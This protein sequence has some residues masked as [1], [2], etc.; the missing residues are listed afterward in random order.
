[1][2]AL[3][4]RP[5]PKTLKE[6]RGL[7]S[8]LSFY[9]RFLPYV[10][11]QLAPFMEQLRDVQSRAGKIKS[12]AAIK[13]DI[14]AES[15]VAW[16][17]IQQLL[18]EKVVLWHLKPEEPFY[19][20]VD[21][22]DVATGGVIFQKYKGDLRAISFFS[23]ILTKPQ[24]AYSASEREML[25][26]VLILQKHRNLL[27]CAKLHVYVDHMALLAIMKSRADT[28]GRLVRWRVEFR[29][30]NI[31][32][33]HLPGIHHGAADWLSRPADDVVKQHDEMINE[34]QRAEDTEIDL[35]SNPFDARL[36]MAATSSTD[37]APQGKKRS[38][39][40]KGQL[41]K[42][43]QDIVSGIRRSTPTREVLI[44]INGT[45]IL[46]AQKV[47]SLCILIK[48]YMQDNVDLDY[49]EQ[50][51]ARKGAIERFARKCVLSKDGVVL[52]PDVLAGLFLVP[53]VPESMRHDI[54]KIG[55]EWDLGHMAGDRL[56]TLIAERG[57]WPNMRVDIDNFVKACPTCMRF[58]PGMRFRAP[59]GY[60]SASYPWEQLT[61]DVVH[62]EKRDSKYPVALCALDTFS[63][64]AVIMPLPN[65]TAEE[66]ILAIKN[67]ILPLG[68]PAVFILDKHPVY[69]S[70]KFQ[71]FIKTIGSSVSLSPGYT[72]THVALVNRLHRTI[73]EILAKCA[74]DDT[75]WV[76]SAW[77][78]TRA[79]NGTCH[80]ATGFSPSM[81][82]NGRT[83]SY[84][85]DQT[86]RN[87]YNER[88]LPLDKRLQIIDKARDIVKRRFAT[89][90]MK[91]LADFEQKVMNQKR[92]PNI[93]ERVMRRL[94]IH[95]RRGGKQ[96]AIRA[97]GPYVVSR[98][99][100]DGVHATIVSEQAQ[101]DDEGIRVRIDELI[102]IK[103]RVCTPIY[104]S[105][106]MVP[107]G[108]VSPLA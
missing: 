81:I 28:A 59:P 87:P 68:T 50:G 19:I 3:L 88:G 6:I 9:N 90:R 104:S 67:Y 71:Q 84:K 52:A 32:W 66:Q 65:E 1:L 101:N 108:A 103:D 73:R 7:T 100:K 21:T 79:Y 72:S 5:P 12:S 89:E 105:L 82:L 70:A 94:D 96:A 69:T 46:D 4:E 86:L 22:S 53:V 54:M 75:D 24:R 37:Q 45:K 16:R 78:A 57:I 48:S 95:R 2:K 14:S 43:Q 30:F 35:T 106:D 18:R 64:F 51:A 44:D 60:F 58:M 8:S 55:H 27:L 20:F 17:K 80:P 41:K 40:Q 23:K 98:V 31:V 29:D 91:Q 10:A 74:T 26:V 25:G 33:H 13:V 77:I 38:S 56:F 97:Y 83:M 34:A 61:L 49:D 107:K 76:D 11:E 93:N 99:D 47:D 92:R 85:I 63:R 36:C 15:K 42:L 62:L 102:P 39:K